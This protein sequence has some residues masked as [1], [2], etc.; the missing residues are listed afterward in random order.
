MDLE[1]VRAAVARHD[2]VA[3]AVAIERDGVPVV[4]FTLRATPDVDP[5]RVASREQLWGNIFDSAFAGATADDPT[6]HSN[7][8][9]DSFTGKPIAAD[10][11]A[12]IVDDTAARITALAPRRV[13]EIGCGTGMVLFRVAPRCE[14]YVGLDLAAAGLEHVRREVERRGLAGVTLER[15]GALDLD[16]LEGPFDCVVVNGTAQY[17]PSV[18]YLAEV[19]RRAAR[20]TT[21]GGHVFLGE[22]RSLPLVR[23]FHAELA[24]ARAKGDEACAA[25]R[26]RVAKAVAAEKELAIDP[27]IGPALLREIG[28]LGSATVRLK[29]G[30]DR[31]E[32]VDV[33]FDLV[34]GVGPRSTE[35]DPAFTRWQGEGVDALV[36]RAKAGER[37]AR[38]HVPNARLSRAR[39]AM[40]WLDGAPDAALVPEGRAAVEAARG[41]VEPESIVRAAEAAG[42]HAHAGW[43]GAGADGDFAFVL[44]RTVEDAA[45][46][47]VA[48][49]RPHADLL[50]LA[51]LANAPV[52]NGALE[53]V[54]A[55]IATLA[56]EVETTARCVHLAAMPSS[57]EPLRAIA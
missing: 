40:A 56:R 48:H 46:S 20:L 18:D 33:R 37:I 8:W 22:L 24:L 53:A 50:P 57:P 26:A 7:A 38:S 9:V 25:V 14:R 17:F 34:L 3:E 35:A 29:R 36:A 45:F 15:R 47:G 52:K 19:V 54:V 51:A 30:L 6:L 13:L 12:R 10:V 49:A 43:S 44:G 31:S 2:A 27:A 42:V 4:F 11:M 55:A 39:A 1:R 21:P 41:G 28:E 32:L 5:A 16:G 23:A